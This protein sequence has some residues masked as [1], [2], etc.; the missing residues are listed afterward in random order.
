V[1][2]RLVP[3]GGEGDLPRELGEFDL[4]VEATGRPGGLN[5]ALDMVRAEGVVVA[6]KIG[7]AHV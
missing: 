5:L 4:V 6:K 3:P 1:A 2:T 7:R